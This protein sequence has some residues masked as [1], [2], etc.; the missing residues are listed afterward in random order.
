[1]HDETLQD[2]LDALRAKMK[3]LLAIVKDTKTSS[4][5]EI[6]DPLSF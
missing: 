6:S 5:K 4:K 3:V 2:K 1:V